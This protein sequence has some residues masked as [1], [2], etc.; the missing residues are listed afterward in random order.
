[1]A[2][3]LGRAIAAAVLGTTA[4]LG[5]ATAA[6]ATTGVDRAAPATRAP[7]VTVNY[8]A[9]LALSNCSGSLIRIAGASDDD[10]ALALTNGHCS[11][12]GMPGAGVVNVNQTSHRTFTLLNSS[13]KGSLGTLT[14]NEILYNTMTD[15]DVTLY[16]LTKSYRQI[17][18]TYGTRA[19]TLAASH[20][21]AGTSID[22]VSGYWRQTYK[23]SIDAFAYQVREAD[24]TWRDSA[25]YTSGC[26]VIGGT[27]GSPVINAA[28]DQV[29]AVN[30]TINESGERCTL[31]NP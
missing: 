25:R 27:S 15:T 16:R 9:I 5:V 11:E 22:V 12:F 3:R 29:I 14:A 2:G 6:S 7:A 19:L 18:Q 23:C 21:T 26:D 28:T 30:N 17:Q 31:D 4:V 24:W 20:P 10:P 8:T 1:M 13:G